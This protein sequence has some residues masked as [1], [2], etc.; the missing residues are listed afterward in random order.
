VT[1]PPP[2][3]AQLFL[4]YSRNDPDAATLLRRQLAQRG[5]EV[6]KDDQSIREGD[7]WLEPR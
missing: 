4:S 5:L 6:F 7:Q 3:P 2:E 1:T